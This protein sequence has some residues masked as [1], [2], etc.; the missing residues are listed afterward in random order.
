LQ[1][2]VLSFYHVGPGEL[3]QVLRLGGKHFSL[4][5]YLAGPL[6]EFFSQKQFL[7]EAKRSLT[8]SITVLSTQT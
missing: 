6:S 3:T 7:F 1:N 8:Q 2:L 5:S 4:V